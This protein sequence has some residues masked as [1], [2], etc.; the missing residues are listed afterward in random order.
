MALLCAN[1]SLREDAAGESREMVPYPVASLMPVSSRLSPAS[2]SV[3]RPFASLGSPPKARKA[4]RLFGLNMSLSISGENAKTPCS[5]PDGSSSVGN[6][7]SVLSHPD[8]VTLDDVHE[9]AF[10]ADTEGRMVEV[11]PPSE[12]EEYCREPMDAPIIMVGMLSVFPRSL[13]SRCGF[14][15][16]MDEFSRDGLTVVLADGGNGASSSS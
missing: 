2:Q 9:L 16:D 1:G 10:D 13:E 15:P 7:L 8:K 14:S 3:I 5:A 4:E 12:D 11:S 6:R